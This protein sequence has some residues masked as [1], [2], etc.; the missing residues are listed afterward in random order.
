MLSQCRV[1]KE[2][3][4]CV[5]DWRLLLQWTVAGQEKG[6]AETG[7]GFVDENESYFVWAIQFLCRFLIVRLSFWLSLSPLSSLQTGQQQ[8]SNFPH[9]EKIT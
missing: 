2:K 4:G 6:V 9:R 7:D 8:A 1:E 3:E 5:T